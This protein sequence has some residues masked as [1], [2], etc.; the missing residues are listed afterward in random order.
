LHSASPYSHGYP[1]ETFRKEKK[2]A[3]LT[4]SE[5]VS[6]KKSA[7]EDEKKG[8]DYKRQNDIVKK[9]EE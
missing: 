4:S 2:P 7:S 5:E 8:K 1:P 3:P 6:E 9:T